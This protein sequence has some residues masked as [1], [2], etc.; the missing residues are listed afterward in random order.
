[1]LPHIIT[2]QTT[3]HD[4]TWTLHCRLDWY[5]LSGWPLWR[6]RPSNRWSVHFRQKVC[7]PLENWSFQKSALH[8]NVSE[9]LVHCE[10]EDVS[11]CLLLFKSADSMYSIS[12]YCRRSE[13]WD[14]GVS[15]T[16]SEQHYQQ[17]HQST[18]SMW[19]SGW[20][21]RI[22]V[23]VH[24]EGARKVLGWWAHFCRR[25]RTVLRLCFVGD[26]TWMATC[27]FE[28]VLFDFLVAKQ[29]PKSK[30]KTMPVSPNFDCKIWNH[31]EYQWHRHPTSRIVSL[32]MPS[33]CRPLWHGTGADAARLPRGRAF[34]SLTRRLPETSFGNPEAT[35]QREE[36]WSGQILF[37]NHVF[38]SISL[39]ETTLV[40]TV[41]LFLQRRVRKL[42]TTLVFFFLRVLR[43]QCF[44]CGVF[45]TWE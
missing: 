11:C 3:W 27:S 1:M 43:K 22:V 35:K 33:P 34:D 29:T 12:L 9:S 37:K 8:F 6:V 10:R 4:S 26:M 7:G 20:M 2:L 42:S 45:S 18:N 17:K 15:G 25:W 44:F 40:F 30:G 14:S 38:Y 13:N 23:K 5:W 41:T 28:L 32:H 31:L 39:E 16:F 21:S 24:V 36:W 19:D